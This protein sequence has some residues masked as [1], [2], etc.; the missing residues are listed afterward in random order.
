MAATL[1]HISIVRERLGRNRRPLVKAVRGIPRRFT[2]RFDSYG[3]P[4]EF[5]ITGREINDRSAASGLIAKLPDAKVIVADSA[6][7]I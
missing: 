4:I 1:K 6:M 2:W 7:I 3:L 5:A